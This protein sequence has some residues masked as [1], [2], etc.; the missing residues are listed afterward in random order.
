M[1]LVIGQIVSL[2]YFLLPD[3]S[4]KVTKVIP[5][6]FWF[7][8]CL[9]CFVVCFGLVCFFLFAIC[10]TTIG[11]LVTADASTSTLY[12]IATEDKLYLPFLKFIIIVTEQNRLRPFLGGFQLSVSI[13][14]IRDRKAS[15]KKILNTCF[16]ITHTGT[17][18]G[19]YSPREA[20]R[21]EWLY[22]DLKQNANCG[23]KLYSSYR[24]QV[25]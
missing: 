4:P 11:L 18:L 7:L 20:L 8:L 10:S 16:I 12:F 13:K 24:R 19:Q 15:G 23:N 2:Q 25:I 6:L 1:I 14:Q 5:F 21:A 22:F 9:Y 3:R 17:L